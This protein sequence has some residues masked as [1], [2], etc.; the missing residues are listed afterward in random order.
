MKI[1]VSACLLGIQCK[2]N[3]EDNY[4]KELSTYLKKHEIIL[5]CPEIEGGLSTPRIPCECKGNKVY[6]KEGLDCT[7]YF[8]KGATKVC[9]KAFE[10][11][12]VVAILKE[13]SPSCGSTMIY[14]GSFTGRKITGKGRTTL[15]LE[16]K[17]IRVYSE[18]NYNE[19]EF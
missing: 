14:D 13:N 9:K 17:G 3:G 16:E 11:N 2:Y 1:L 19:I 6:N 7:K 5:C 8:N 18:K 12:A 4:N 10:E 15:Q